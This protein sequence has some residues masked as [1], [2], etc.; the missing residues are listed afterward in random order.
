MNKTI[1]IV[2]NTKEGI[3]CIAYDSPYNLALLGFVKKS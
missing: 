1:K 3:L 2:P